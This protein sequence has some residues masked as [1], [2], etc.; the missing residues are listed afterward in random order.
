MRRPTLFGMNGLLGEDSLRFA[1]FTGL[2]TGIYRAALCGLRN[3]LRE[4]SMLSKYCA[5][6]IAAHSVMLLPKA[7]RVPIAVYMF[8]RALRVIVE[9]AARHHQ[10]K[11]PIRVLKDVK[12]L[13]TGLFSFTA[14]VILS[15]F[16]CAP[17]M[18]PKGYLTFL[19]LS[20]IHISEPT[21]LLSISYAVFCLKKKK[22]T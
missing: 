21:R 16:L 6:Y 12:H 3:L 8:V 13:D 9:G 17:Q 11:L 2:Y 20:L 1:G 19:Y 4:D 5:G 10:D 15:S 14:G 22:K 7:D 18:L